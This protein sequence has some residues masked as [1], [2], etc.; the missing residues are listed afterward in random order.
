MSEKAIAVVPGVQGAG[1][2]VVV[3]PGVQGTGLPVW[4]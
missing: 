3:V 1:L 4:C 2:P